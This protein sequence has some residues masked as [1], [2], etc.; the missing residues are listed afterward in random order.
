MATGGQSSTPALTFPCPDEDIFADKASFPGFRELPCDKEVDLNYYKLNEMSGLYE[1]IRTW[2][3]MGEI[4]HDELSQHAFL[5]NRVYVSDRNRSREIPI[6]FYPEDGF[7]DFTQLKNG[8]TICILGAEYHHF[9][10]G[11]IGLRVENLTKIKV[12]PC[13][14]DDL[15][16]VSTQCWKSKKMSVCWNC[17]KKG[18]NTQKLS[19]CARC[20]VGLYCGKK[21]QTEDWKARHK[22]RCKAITEFTRFHMWMKNDGLPIFR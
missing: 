19:K 18:C 12:I 17:D 2:C 20:M 9:L 1:P 21:C 6:F 22:V 14:L 15:F 7:F 11:Q 10:D 3:F 4:S 13:R 8:R 5:K 16:D